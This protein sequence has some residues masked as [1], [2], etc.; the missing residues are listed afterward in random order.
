MGKPINYFNIFKTYRF[1]KPPFFAVS[2][3]YDQ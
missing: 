3:G 1:V 2:E